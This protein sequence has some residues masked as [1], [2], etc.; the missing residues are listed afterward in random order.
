M[1]MDKRFHTILLA[2]ITTLIMAIAGCSDQTHTDF[3][4]LL[5]ELASKD[6]TIDSDDWS[7]I[8]S[9]IES[10]KAEMDDFYDNGNINANAVKSYISDLFAN[11]RPPLDIKFTGIGTAKFMSVKFYLERS[12]SMVAYDAPE[13]DGRFKATIVKMLNSLPGHNTD[14]KIYVVNSSINAYPKG[15]DSFIADSNIFE[16]TK[17]IGDPSYTDFSAIF[18]SILNKTSSNELSI[19]VTDMIYSTRNMAG[20]NPQKVFAEAR[21]MTSAVFKDAVKDKGMLIL[22]MKSSYDGFYYPYNSPSKRLAYNGQR[23]YYIIIVGSND[24]MARITQDKSYSTF[25]EFTSLPGF[26]N[27]Y[28]F[29]TSGLYKP[30]YSLLLRNGNISGRFQP[31]RGQGNRITKIEGMANDPATGC[32]RLALAVDL[33]GMLIPGNYLCDKAN[34]Q[35]SS[36]TPVTLKSIVPISAKDMT[37]A[38]KKYIGTATHIMVLETKDIS[39]RQTVS[40]RLLNKL[41]EW[42]AASS[43]DDD[44]DCSA[45]NFPST[46]FGLSY[47]L[48]GIYDSY[49]LNSNGHPYYFD[50]ELEFDK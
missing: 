8:T 16:A 4:R 37:P 19:L 25:A 48:N 33:G 23:P 47:L 7:K 26:Q 42:V 38:E 31:L 12:G 30:Y 10:H 17:G 40:I 15:F 45:P 3:D 22:K 14:N 46:T 29:E 27:M 1:F 13:G 20:V 6:S 32:T 41:P 28:L 2:A 5:V 36:D 34:Y 39:H 21:G 24:N 9:F 50:I 44:T 11:R 49:G 18:D 43:C 35:I